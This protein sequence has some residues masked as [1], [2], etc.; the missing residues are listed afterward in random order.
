MESVAIGLLGVIAVLSGLILRRL[1]RL[2]GPGRRDALPREIPPAAPQSPDEANP[3]A[4]RLQKQMQEGL[5]NI[6]NYGGP[7]SPKDGE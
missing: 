4:D 3:R 1:L 5:D 7:F 2:E 6:M